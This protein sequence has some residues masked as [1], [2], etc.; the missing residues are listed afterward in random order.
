MPFTTGELANIANSTLD[1]YLDK[2]KV[3]KN[4]VQDKPMMAAFEEAA[5]TFPGGKGNLS[6]AVKSGQGGGA[7]QGY[8]H[9]DQVGY[10]NPANTLRVNYPWKEHHIGLG[11]THTELKTDG[12]TVIEDGADQTTREKDGR[13]AFALANLFEEKL[14]EMEEDRRRSWD[15][16]IHG[17][18]TSSS[19][20]LAGIGAFLLAAPA[21]GSTGGLSRVTYPWWRNR[22]ATAANG[23]AGGQGAITVNAAG[24]GALIQFMQKESRQLKRYAQGGVRHKLF[25]GSDF[26]DGYERELRANGRYTETGFS[27]GEAVD[28]KMA[29]VRWG[30]NVFTYDP[31]L[32]DL[33]LSK[34]CYVLDMRSG[35]RLYYM[36][37]EKNKKAS[38]PRPYDR[39]VL[40]RGLTSTAVMAARQLN[41]SAIWDIA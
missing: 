17:D 14:D 11:I 36:A 7:F 32:D 41:T 34:R 24:G 21:A 6:L 28:G 25:A 3:G 2:G 30:G 27:S 12:I 37:G 38:P 9:D 8:T 26:I 1:F 20:S 33:G 4:N 13:E 39:Y 35:P 22:A 10:Y 16:L 40:Y 29:D 18:G 31:T 5:G 23:T 15:L 19:K